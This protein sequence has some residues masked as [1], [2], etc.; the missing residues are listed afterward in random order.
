[1]I[2]WMNTLM[3]P[4]LQFRENAKSEVEFCCERSYLLARAG[5][6]DKASSFLRV[7]GRRSGLGLLPK[8]DGFPVRNIFAIAVGRPQSPGVLP[9][10]AAHTVT[11]SFFTPDALL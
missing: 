11:S 9:S 1:M 4:Q 5:Q 8:N 7:I 2:A 10:D 6:Y 3:S